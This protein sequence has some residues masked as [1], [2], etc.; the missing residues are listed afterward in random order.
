MHINCNCIEWKFCVKISS[1]IDYRLAWWCDCRCRCRC[2]CFHFVYCSEWMSVWELFSL[3]FCCIIIN[4]IILTKRPT[5][6]ILK[7]ESNEKCK[8][9]K[10]Q[11]RRRRRRRQARREIYDTCVCV[12]GNVY[13]SVYSAR[14]CCTVFVFPCRFESSFTTTTTTIICKSVTVFLK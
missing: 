3:L 7:H 5:K 1:G 13:L 9:K 6:R 10:R 14:S 12:W 8:T 2:C 11:R 4:I